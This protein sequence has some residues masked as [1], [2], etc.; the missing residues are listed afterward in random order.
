MDGCIVFVEGDSRCIRG[1]VV[2]SD[3]ADGGIRPGSQ[4]LSSLA[5]SLPDHI[6]SSESKKSLFWPIRFYRQPRRWPAMFFFL[7]LSSGTKTRRLL[8]VPDL[9]LAVSQRF[10][11]Q[12][13]INC[14]SLP[15]ERRVFGMDPMSLHGKKGI[16]CMF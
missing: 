4:F 3:R 10:N 7:C 8:A 12:S 13:L 11:D 2:N 14:G 15:H 9:V 1:V 16:P 5:M 6:L